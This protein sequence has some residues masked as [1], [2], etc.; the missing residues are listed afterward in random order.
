MPGT[1]V[2][3]EWDELEGVFEGRYWESQKESDREVEVL[4]EMCG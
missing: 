2:C 1:G 4:N 3:M